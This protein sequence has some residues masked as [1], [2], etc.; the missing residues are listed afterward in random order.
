MIIDYVRGTL[1]NLESLC[2]SDCNSTNNVNVSSDICN[3]NENVDV[4]SDEHVPFVS[5]S[6]TAETGP[7]ISE[8]YSKG[9]NNSNLSQTC[10]AKLT[11]ANNGVTFV[12]NQKAFI[13]NGNNNKKYAV[14][15]F[16]KESCQCPATG[17]CYHM[18]AA[19]ITMG[20]NIK[21]LILSSCLRIV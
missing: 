4:G 1:E 10:L 3:S 19:R 14:T 13:V 5:E 6:I 16:P 20:D 11:V 2:K 15:L 7:K 21:Q 17:T 12:E 9:V 18:L 8:T